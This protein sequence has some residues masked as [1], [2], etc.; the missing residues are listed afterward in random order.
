[1]HPSKSTC[2]LRTIPILFTYTTSMDPIIKKNPY[3]EFV[4]DTKHSPRL[5]PEQQKLPALCAGL[6]DEKK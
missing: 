4:V 2:I 6:F 5:T 3:L 1:M